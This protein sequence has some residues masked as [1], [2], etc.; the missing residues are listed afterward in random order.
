MSDTDK[1]D[2]LRADLDY[3]KLI[4]KASP[5]LRLYI[6]ALEQENA[7]LRQEVLELRQSAGRRQRSE[8]ARESR[9]ELEPAAVVTVRHPDDVMVITITGQGQAKRTPLNAYAAQRRGGVG[10]F[11]IQSSRDDP[12]AHLA[13]ARASAALLILTNRGRAFRVSVD[14]LPLTEVRGRGA[15]LPERLRFTDDETIG[16][17]LPLDEERETR[18][19]VLVATA[20]GWVRPFHRNYLGLR[21]QPGTLLVDPKRGGPPVAMTLSDGAGDVLLVARSG[22]GYRFEEQLVR[23]EGVRGIQVRPD[24]AV[25]GLAAISGDDDEVLLVTA[26]GQGTRRQMAGFAANKS[27]GGQ[28]KVIMKTEA[29]VGAARVS[30]SDDVLLITGFAKIIRFAAGEAPAKSGNVQGVNVMDARGDRVTALAVVPAPAAGN[31][32][33]VVDEN[34]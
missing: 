24:D 28:G 8:L 25:V 20:S 13:V 15:S 16:A 1:F 34:D 7:R 14:G 22:L 3:D 9:S 27:P 18:N 26:D 32:T 11:D 6:R 21:L 23:R 12:A 31:A 4:E 5:A 33:S 19:N 29:L 2:E 17:V 10:V 30:D